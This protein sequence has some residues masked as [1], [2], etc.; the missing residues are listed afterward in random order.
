MLDSGIIRKF[1]EQLVDNHHVP[2]LNYHSTR[3]LVYLGYNDTAQYV[4][5]HNL[6]VSAARRGVMH[7]GTI[8]AWENSEMCDRSVYES[9]VKCFKM[10]FDADPARKNATRI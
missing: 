8:G 9:S 4:F 10:L 3:G 6:K 2:V 7:V 5:E 1:R